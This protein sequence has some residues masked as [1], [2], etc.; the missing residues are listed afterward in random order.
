[1]KAIKTISFIIC[2]LFAQTAFAQKDSS[3]VLVKTFTGDIVNVALD[4][5]DNIYLTSSTGQIK[6]LSPAGD[7]LS[8]YNQVRNFG[9]PFSID[10]SNPLK[11]LLFYKD[12]SSVVV[13]DRFLAVRATI[14]LRRQNI[15]QPTAV[16][17]SYDNN[18]WVFD[19]FDSKLKRIDE[20]GNL[21]SETSDLRIAINQSISP[22]RI[23]NDNKTVYLAD[24]TNGIFVFDNY[25]TFKRKVP[26]TKW[27]SLEVIQN[28]II[29]IQNGFISIYDPAT[30]VER[31]QKLPVF[32][33]Y[34]SAFTHANRFVL[35]SKDSVQIYRTGF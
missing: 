1:V 31:K 10:V 6:K 20:Q 17:L 22:Q 25:G 15:L 21:L 4:N 19:E 8:V 23:L 29:S 28:H 32:Q 18:I 27:Q 16:G 24:T 13:L 12:F 11:I 3:F 9:Q 5:L 2:C 34:L 26:I 14:D 30:F 7:S 33:S 35:L